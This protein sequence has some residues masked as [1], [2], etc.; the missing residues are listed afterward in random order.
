[1]KKILFSLF[2]LLT[3]TAVMAQAPQRISYQSIIRDANKVVVASSPVGIKISLLQG[4]ATGPAVYVETH[5]ITTNAN[6]LV[7]LNIGE[8]TAIA[9]SFAG[10]DWANGPYLIQT[11][12]DP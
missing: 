5:G 10:I 11:A 8:G 4:T 7:S 3:F 6:G 1:M 2:F 12:T 9:G